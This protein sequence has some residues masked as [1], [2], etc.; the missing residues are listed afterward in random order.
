MRLHCA[1]SHPSID[2]RILTCMPNNGIILCIVKEIHHASHTSEWDV[3][4]FVEEHG[5]LFQRA[6]HRDC[7]ITVHTSLHLTPDP[8][9]PLSL[10]TAHCPHQKPSFTLRALLVCHA[11]SHTNF[12]TGRSVGIGFN[13]FVCT[14]TCMFDT[15][16]CMKDRA[17]GS[18]IKRNLQTEL[19]N[20]TGFL[21]DSTHRQQL[22]SDS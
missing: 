16:I 11:T 21:K 20:Y 22:P 4:A 19:I 8:Q 6:S 3:N 15:A 7:A 12:L 13:A 1:S 2:E 5:K 14:F 9:H 10:L 18:K 17:L